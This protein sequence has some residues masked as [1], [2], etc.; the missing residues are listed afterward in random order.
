MSSKA[1]TIRPQLGSPHYII[2]WENGGE[3]PAMLHGAFTTPADAKRAIAVWE[4][5]ART[6]PVEVKEISRDDVPRRG[7]LPMKS[8]EG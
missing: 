6:E 1:L 2:L 8:I 7:R 4:A 3:V 5:S